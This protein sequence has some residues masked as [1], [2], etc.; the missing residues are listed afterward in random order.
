MQIFAA[1]DEAL[2]FGRDFE[3]FLRAFV[4]ARLQSVVERR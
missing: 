2:L 1:V 4:R 3:R